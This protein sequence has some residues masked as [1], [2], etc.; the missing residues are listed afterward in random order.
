MIFSFCY[1]CQYLCTCLNFSFSLAYLTIRPPSTHFVDVH[2]SVR[3]QA[4]HI[5][6]QGTRF[7]QHAVRKVFIEIHERSLV[8]LS[9]ANADNSKEI[10]QTSQLRKRSDEFTNYR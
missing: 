1:L 3:Q 4:Q 10:S 9:Q 2:I 8:G 6:K 7:Q 5:F